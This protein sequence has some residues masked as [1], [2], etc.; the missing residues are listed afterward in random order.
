MAVGTLD[1]NGDRYAACLGQQAALDALLAPVRPVRPGFFE[2]ERGACVTAP[3]MDSHD[4]SI[5]L[6]SS[7][8][9]SP[10][11]Q[12]DSNTLPSVHSRKRRYAELQEQMPV[13]LRA[14]QW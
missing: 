7:W 13:A 6:S 12:R 8:A 5:P 3:S 9:V 2:S 11:L 4:Q 14:F 10:L 1:G